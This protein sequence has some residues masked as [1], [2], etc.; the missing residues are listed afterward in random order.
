M[1]RGRS[2]HIGVNE[3][4]VA[5]D[6]YPKRPGPLRSAEHDARSMYRLAMQEGLDAALFTGEAATIA[7]VEAAILAASRELHAGDLLVL[8]FAGHGGRLPDVLYSDMPRPAGGQNRW[9]DKHGN[10]HDEAWCLW[11]GVLLDDRI[12]E[13]LA[14]FE[15]GVRIYV[16]SDSC[17]GGSILRLMMEA[18]A[19]LRA[20]NAPPSATAQEPDVKASVLLLAACNDD[21]KTA[22][23]GEHGLFTKELLKVWNDGAFDGSHNDL[24][25]ALKRTR[26]KTTEFRVGPPDPAFEAG[27]PF[28]T[29]RVSRFIPPLKV[30]LCWFTQPAND[31]RCQAVAREIFG[32]LHRP[33]T[34][35]GAADDP[36]QRPGL[37]I[38]V[39][40]GRDLGGLID[41]LERPA[42]D[43]DAEPEVGARLVVV[44]LDRRAYSELPN[45]EV[46]ARAV[47][48]W[49]GDGAVRRNERLLPI[50]LDGPWTAELG[51]V[52]AMLA[53]M[54]VKPKTPQRRWQVPADVAIVAGRL[55]LRKL[56]DRD[57]PRPRVLISHTK[58][59]GR[60][61]AK[62]LAKRMEG[63]TRV[64]AWYDENDVD[65]GDEL[66]SQ[67]ER[68]V[69]HGVVLV[70]R[71]DR[72]S[73]SP[74]CGLE[75]LRA[76]QRRTPMVTLLDGSDGEPAPSAYG[77]NHPTIVWRAGR[78]DE[79]I[80]RCVQAWLH[81]H[82]FNA[83][84]AVALAH[85]G[86]PATAE[87]LSRRPELLDVAHR[88]NAAVERR[89]LV[90]PDPPMTEIESALLR[91]AR[92]D[93]RMA[94][95]STMLGRAS[96]AADPTPPLAGC[97]LAFSLSIAEDL[98][99]LTAAGGGS[100]LTS[101]HLDDVLYTIV[102]TTLHAGV[103]VAY[104]G[105]FRGRGQRGYAAQ[106][107]DLHR[108]RRRLGT[109]ARSQLLAFVR[110]GVGR[111]GDGDVD[112]WPVPVPALPAGDVDDDVRDI[113]W[114]MN[115]REEMAQRSH[116]R[117][118][119]GGQARAMVTADGTGYR[120]PWPG[121]LEECWRMAAAGKG[122][123]VIGALGGFAGVLARM[124]TTGEVPREF[125]RATFVGTRVEELAARVDVARRA[126]RGTVTKEVL[127]ANDDGSLLGADEMA[128][129][130]LTKWK[131]FCDGDVAAWRN[132]LSVRDNRRL[133]R[134]TDPTEI[135]QLVFNGLRK[136]MPAGLPALDIALY[137]GDIASAVDVDGYAV[138]TTPGLQHVGALLSLDQQ[139]S[140]RLGREVAKRGELG[141][142]DA[143]VV[144][145]IA[146]DTDGLA[147]RRVLVAGLPLPAAGGTLSSEAIRKLGAE[148]ARVAAHEQLAS[149][150]VAPFGTT[151]GL[152]TR[153]SVV[154]L[155]DAVNAARSPLLRTVVVCEVNRE[156]Y[157]TLRRAYVGDDNVRELRAGPVRGGPD[158]GVVVHAHASEDASGVTMQTTIY[159]ADDRRAVV[160]MGSGALPSADWQQLHTRPPWTRATT[161]LNGMLRELL[162]PPMF[163]L[164]ATAAGRR[165][166]LVANDLA[167]SVPWE[168]LTPREGDIPA[169][170]A[171]IARRVAMTGDSRPPA[172]RASTD[173][174]LRILLV[175]NPTGDLPDAEAEG[176]AVQAALRER[177][178]VD[179]V[180]I[181]GAAATLAAVSEQLATGAF[182][183]LHYAGHARFV[184]AN[185][186]ASGLVLA[187]REVFTGAAFDR[188]GAR[189]PRLVVLG[190]CESAQ[191]GSDANVAQQPPAPSAPL[192]AEQP[193]A[194]ALLRGGVATL[195]GTFYPV[196]D[197]ASRQFATRLYTGLA[198]GLPVGVA[199][200]DARRHLHTAGAV[201][202][203]NFLLYG[204]D[205]LIL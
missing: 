103:Q 144:V 100:G 76:K 200:V 61:R 202:W 151:M 153:E 120:G 42:Y 140:G 102:L 18:Q 49:T 182:D 94:T 23:D 110:P 46:L 188:S 15:R 170:G 124:L 189:V 31:P 65:R 160:P 156:R 87:I 199:V 13:L 39:E 112:F 62:R 77:G 172:D 99:S 5:S 159:A 28:T 185:P 171:G 64:S 158:S 85:A 17:Y 72:Y 196:A 8:T 26:E 121:V 198:A 173:G 40:M 74:W 92:P 89:L 109:G 166:V 157:D 141:N 129:G 126:L 184:A 192:G 111:D 50:V 117:V 143:P 45:R 180:P 137:H 83:R 70:V 161:T 133:M 96:M 20:S 169:L 22:E 6:A 47:R 48:R 14:A 167:S 81:G 115:M 35:D 125:K 57:P 32:F 25:V 118:V 168:F 114:T 146:V 186:G 191:L 69:E 178:D 1:L 179:V 136:M 177:A 164:L 145:A 68:A 52:S 79:V 36:V 78:E 174:L 108:A 130:L 82:H 4:S 163:E 203:G 105:D 122:L 139:M 101:A 86:L 67:L 134:S 138:T 135:A 204:D 44:I 97:T 181:R 165:V 107:S 7:S 75:L 29:A 193:F 11:D 149:L 33:V 16:V 56:G 9:I 58:A 183:V 197:R 95:P 54:V 12:S 150:A 205:G 38:P 195:V 190:G 30:H 43:R 71:T 90:Y 127:L 148:I 104:G 201:D 194:A 113:L 51:D 19:A 175:V 119:L 59:D 37:E 27:R 98:S 155:L 187:N 88:G 41:A 2:I 24:F 93:L 10:G 142:P 128:A 106:L 3:V 63:H 80:A 73:D 91:S 154:A 34:D 132:G 176:D 131:Q 21:Q 162:G 123:Y 66:V 152:E 84:A 60:A 53:G 116:A 55:L 147:G